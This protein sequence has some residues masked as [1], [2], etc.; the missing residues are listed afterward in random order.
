MS[1]SETD[2]QK[3]INFNTLSLRLYDDWEIAFEEIYY[4]QYVVG[5]GVGIN[6][7]GLTKEEIN[8]FKTKHELW[9]KKKRLK[10]N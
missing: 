7:S 2:T 8:S 9:L 1:I 5:T 3:S 10:L 4:L 6:F